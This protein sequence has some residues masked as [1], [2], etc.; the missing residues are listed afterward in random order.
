MKATSDEL[1]VSWAAPHEHGSPITH[2]HVELVGSKQTVDDESSN[3]ATITDLRASTSYRL[4]SSCHMAI[5]L[6]LHCC[7]LC[8]ALAPINSSIFISKYPSQIHCS[9]TGSEFQCG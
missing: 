3:R 7:H 6:L 9:F 1:T 8:A 5:S 4:V 2:Y